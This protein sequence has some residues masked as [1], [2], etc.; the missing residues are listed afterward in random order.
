MA[1]HPGPKTKVF[2]S[3]KEYRRWLELLALQAAGK[4]QGLQKQRSFPLRS[5]NGT[6]I[7]RYRADFVYIERGV[8]IIEDVKSK[9]TRATRMY[10]LKRK[11]M[12]AEHGVVIRET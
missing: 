4:I 12:L 11:W 2:D 7:A 5:S 1:D 6:I 9:P 10:Q 8:R 3:L